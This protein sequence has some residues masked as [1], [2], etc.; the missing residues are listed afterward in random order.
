MDGKEVDGEQRAPHPQPHAVFVGSG[1]CGRESQPQLPL[2]W[3]EAG[4]GVLQ[5]MGLTEGR[6]PRAWSS[7]VREGGIGQPEST[8]AAQKR[9]GTGHGNSSWKDQSGNWVTLGGAPWSRRDRA[10]RK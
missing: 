4:Y 2:A 6:K 1:C 7:H 5:W 10:V 3:M 8:D 9:A